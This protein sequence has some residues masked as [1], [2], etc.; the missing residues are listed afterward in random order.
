[1]AWSV[2]NHN[3]MVLQHSSP[4]CCNW[5]CLPRCLC[6]SSLSCYFSWHYGK[7]ARSSHIKYMNISLWNLCLNKNSEF[8]CSTDPFVYFLF[9]PCHSP[10]SSP[11]LISKIINI[12]SILLL[13]SPTFISIKWHKANHFL[14]DSD[15]WRYAYTSSE[16]IF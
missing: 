6:P 4:C 2:T 15:L 10:E 3:L 9:Y 13:Q 1:M 11:T 7:E 8:I 14:H 16:C 12:L 5:S